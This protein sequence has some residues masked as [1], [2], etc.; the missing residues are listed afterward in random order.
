MA[1]LPDKVHLVG[2]VNLDSIADVFRICGKALGRRLRR[3][4]DGEPGPRRMWL[5]W[6]YFMLASCRI[7]GSSAAAVAIASANPVGLIVVGGLK[8]YGAAS[9]RTG[10]EGRAKSTAD[11]IAAQLKIRF[12]D[13]G[14]IAQD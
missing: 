14:W 1:E 8:I 11:E 12:Q 4:P 13:R 5:G 10:L 3:I 9:G 6:Q 2:S 7:R